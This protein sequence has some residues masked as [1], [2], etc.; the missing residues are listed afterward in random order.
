MNRQV[1]DYDVPSLE[2]MQKRGKKGK[3]RE[4]SLVYMPNHHLKRS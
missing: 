1:D 4:S 2:I 3:R